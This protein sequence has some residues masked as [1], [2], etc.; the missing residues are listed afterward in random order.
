MS[1][2]QPGSIGKK[3]AISLTQ[4]GSGSMSKTGDTRI[5]ITRESLSTAAVRTGTGASANSISSG[6]KS[7]AETSL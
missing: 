7:A 4:N 5:V 6:E 2:A 1:Y 3:G